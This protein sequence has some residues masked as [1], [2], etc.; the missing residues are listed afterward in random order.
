MQKILFT[1]INLRTSIYEEG[2]ISNDIKNNV[3]ACMKYTC[4]LFELID[5]SIIQIRMIKSELKKYED[6]TLCF[7][8]GQVN[9]YFK[10]LDIIE[11]NTSNTRAILK[12]MSLNLYSIP[13]LSEK[14]LGKNFV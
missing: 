4:Q 5:T 11:T 12:C 2:K 6:D 13:L 8:K 14:F 9:L 1:E 7:S 3:Y 10:Y